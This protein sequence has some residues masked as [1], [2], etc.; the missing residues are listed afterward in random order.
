MDKSDGTQ[1]LEV[2]GQN[3]GGDWQETPVT[4][5]WNVLGDAD[6]DGLPDAWELANG[7]NANDP[8]DAVLD[9]DNDGQTNAQEYTAATNPQ[10]ANSRFTATASATL[11]PG[12]YSITFAAIA[13]KSYTVRYKD[14]LTA[15][16]WTVL[17]H[18]PVQTV[19]GPL[20]VLDTPVATVRRFYQVAT[21]QQP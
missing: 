21:P 4:R 19:S 16:T 18:F 15:A 14:D 17:Q 5:T 13:G 6:N 20:T 11:T 8:L 9:A 7:L 3:S 12:E 1:T 10:N 2:I